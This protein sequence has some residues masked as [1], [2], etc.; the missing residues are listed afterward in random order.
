M[1]SYQRAL[2]LTVI[3]IG[4]IIIQCSYAIPDARND[5]DDLVAEASS[6]SFAV[7]DHSYEVGKICTLILEIWRLTH[8]N[9]VFYII[10]YT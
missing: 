10:L 1:R 4:I 2:T 9:T 8:F 3:H 6:R 7:I 5:G